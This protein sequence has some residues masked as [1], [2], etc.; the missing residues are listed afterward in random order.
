ML[1]FSVFQNK[2]QEVSSNVLILLYPQH[3]IQYNYELL[4]DTSTNDEDHLLASYSLVRVLRQ[5][6]PGTSITF[7]Y[8]H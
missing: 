4:N 3:K 7:K 2:N 6:I 5:T 8:M 1:K